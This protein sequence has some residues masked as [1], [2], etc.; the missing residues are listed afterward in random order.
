MQCALQLCKCY[1]Q[2]K[3]YLEA[4]AELFGLWTKQQEIGS[5]PRS[6]METARYTLID[7]ERQSSNEAAM[8]WRK[9][10]WREYPQEFTKMMPGAALDLAIDLAS[11]KRWDD[12]E[13]ISRRLW[14]DILD[15]RKTDMWFDTGLLYS[16]CLT[17]GQ[18]N[19]KYPAAKEV[20]ERLWGAI[21]KAPS[22]GYGSVFGVANNHT[23]N[24]EYLADV[25]LRDTCRRAWRMVKSEPNHADSTQVMYLGARYTRALLQDNKK[26]EAVNIAREVFQM[27]KAKATSGDKEWSRRALESCKF[28][29]ERLEDWDSTA[30]VDEVRDLKG[31]LREF[32]TS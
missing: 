18:N 21:S 2:H 8:D 7:L 23:H 28:L 16:R 22:T 29:I 3:K 17:N 27:R 13:L 15:G 11:L 31:Q 12:A 30:T 25:A 24:L 4:Q 26:S 32:E 20:S 10:L 14:A 9:K 6:L 19:A 5:S 1:I